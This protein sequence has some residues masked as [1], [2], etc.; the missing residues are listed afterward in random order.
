MHAI[1]SRNAV[2]RLSFL[3]GRR[4]IAFQRCFAWRS[5][6][7]ARALQ[8]PGTC[9]NYF[10]IIASPPPFYH[11]LRRA[12]LVRDIYFDQSGKQQL[13]GVLLN[14]ILCSDRESEGE[15]SVCID[16]AASSKLQS[17]SILDGMW[18][19]TPEYI[20]KQ[21]NKYLG[22]LLN[23]VTTFNEK[24]SKTGPNYLR[25]YHIPRNNGACL[26]TVLP[27]APCICTAYNYMLKCHV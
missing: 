12:M 22:L 9:S 6:H 20:N 13:I 2:L 1:L 26:P 3:L 23:Y 11:Q 24:H 19:C 25:L 17:N 8:Y 27:L 14:G 4:R 15:Q 5:Q 10:Q 21:T 16:E 18:V 7:C